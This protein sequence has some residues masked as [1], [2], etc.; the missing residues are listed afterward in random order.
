MSRWKVILGSWVVLC[1]LRG[2]AMGVDLHQPPA[3][4]AVDK[5]IAMDAGATAQ[6]G[7]RWSCALVSVTNV[8]YVVAGVK[9]QVNEIVAAT[10]SDARTA[11][12]ELLK[13]KGD[14]SLVRRDG[15][16][17]YELVCSDVR[18]ARVAK[19]VFGFQPSVVSYRISFLCAPLVSCDSM[20]WNRLFNLFLELDRAE[21]AEAAEATK[22]KIAELREKFEFG[23]EL[24][25]RQRGLGDRQIAFT[26]D[27]APESASSADGSDL[28][29]YRFGKLPFIAGVPHVKVVATITSDRAGPS[30]EIKIPVDAFLTATPHWPTESPEI[31]ELVAELTRGVES[32][33]LKV[34]AILRWFGDA[35]H[36]RYG[37]DIVGS[38]YGVTKLLA[39]RFGRCWDYSDLFVTLC[40]AGGV[41]ARQVAG[42]LHRQSG[43]VWAE[44]FVAGRWQQVD[45]TSQM[46]C[47]S[48]Y[49]AYMTSDGGEL[50]LVYVSPVSIEVIPTPGG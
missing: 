6:L 29:T 41:P 39:Q 32:P 22:A 17:V 20:A 2:G 26:F 46:A 27:P 31:V 40:R 48:D 45:P 37:G 10:E 18:L 43:H 25:L 1:V 7:Q 5:T 4:W 35:S 47:G 8:I 16:K 11:E 3:G 36:I 28:V 19:D 34:A 33:E 44:V 12:V 23:Q 21:G 30:R 50:P 9:C 42:W 14:P 15:A 13:L 38:R 49:I 24:T